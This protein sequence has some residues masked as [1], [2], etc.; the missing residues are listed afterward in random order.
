MPASDYYNALGVSR[1]ATSDEIRKAYKKIA[2]ESHPDAKPGD[3]AAAERFKKAAEAYEVLGDEEKRKKYDQFGDNW[4]Y[5]D[6]MGA[7][8]RGGGPRPGA[9]GQQF[10]FDPSDMFGAG[11]FDLG[12]LF[13]GGRGRR[14]R[15]MRGSDLQ[16]EIQVPFSVAA[17][18]GSHDLTL[19]TGSSQERLTVKI[20]PGMKDGGVVRLRGQGQAGQNGGPAGDL[21][22]TVRVA[23][24][25]FF[26]R[27]QDDLII[28]VPVTFTEAALG[29]KVDVPTLSEGLVTL[30]IPAGASSGTRLRMKGKGIANA[31]TKV[32]GDQ[33]VVVK[34]VSPPLQGRVKELLEQLAEEAPQNPRAAMW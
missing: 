30:K 9:G 34:I 27:D 7:G 3:K 15:S 10:D 1:S 29:A 2:K 11:G 20:P 26:K 23:P 25:P 21:L 13:G 22:V 32:S 28:E 31:K 24:H 16:T 12:D 5:A 19:A 4:K 18:G 33:Y 17:L 14:Q 8:A 6:Q